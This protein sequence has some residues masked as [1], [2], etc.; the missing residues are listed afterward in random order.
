MFCEGSH[1]M[2]TSLQ[3]GLCGTRARWEVYF[4]LHGR[5]VGSERHRGWRVIC[6]GHIESWRCNGN[7]IAP[8]KIAY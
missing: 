8:L 3:E 1:S 6:D 5:D 7:T 4:R 2:K